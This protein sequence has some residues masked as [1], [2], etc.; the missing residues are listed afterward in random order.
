MIVDELQ[1]VPRWGGTGFGRSLLQLAEKVVRRS[2]MLLVSDC[3]DDVEAIRQGL[4][5]LRYRKHEVMLL[6]VM[7][8]AEL[9]F[10]Y[11]SVTMFKGMEETGELL[12]EPR[13][14][15]QA[16]LKEMQAHNLE[17]ARVCRGMG[18]EHGLIDSGEPLD[19]TLS[20]FLARRLA[21][22]K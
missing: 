22:M 13:A 14:L 20:A 17:L 21:R 1:A 16:Y 7:D 2:V 4:M 12:V 3:F 19:V 9:T 10:P 8:P 6:Q 5:Q 11:D 15:R 18:V